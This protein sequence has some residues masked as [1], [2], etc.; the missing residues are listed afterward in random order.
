M[1]NEIES[2]NGQASSETP[3]VGY[4]VLPAVLYA[5]WKQS[6]SRKVDED[7]IT[8]HLGMDDGSPLCGIHKQYPDIYHSG[9]EPVIYNEA[10]FNLCCQRCLKVARSKH[11]W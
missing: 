11:G 8:V 4:A 2:T 9:F 3:I 10:T 6:H 5:V 7:Y 1:K